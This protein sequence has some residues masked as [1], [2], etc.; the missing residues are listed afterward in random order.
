MAKEENKKPDIWLIVLRFLV[1]L[2]LN[3]GASVCG[4]LAKD[5]IGDVHLW[6]M[7][8]SLLALFMVAGSVL[9]DWLIRRS[10]GKKNVE[11]GMAFVDGQRL[12]VD[13]DP[14]AAY[15]RLRLVSVAAV[16]W[17]VV[18]FLLG[19]ALAFLEG[20]A[21]NAGSFGQIASLYLLYGFAARVIV[22]REK[23]DYSQARS[24]ED[25]PQLYALAKETANEL[26][27]AG[28]IH[29]YT[30]FDMGGYG[31]CNASIS[32][33]NGH[34]CL[35]ISAL[36]L[37]VLNRQEM[38]QIL[39][40]EFGHIEGV[41]HNRDKGFYKLLDFLRGEGDDSI[42]VLTGLGL[43]LPVALLSLEGLFYMIYSS[44][45]KEAEADSAASS[46]GDR[47]AQASALAKTNAYR[48]YY[49]NLEPYVNHYRSEEVPKSYA[50]DWLDAYRT[51]LLE[52]AAR[53][54]ELLEKELPARQNSHPTFRQRWDA[55]GNCPYSLEPSELDSPYGQECR[56]AVEIADRGLAEGEE[57]YKKAREE[58]HC[59]SMEI[60]GAYEQAPE[61][62]TPETMRPVIEAYYELG[63]PEKSE[64]VCER[65]IGE[66]DSPFATA[67]ACF[68]KGSL[69]LRRFDPAGIDL[70]YQAVN[71]NNNYVDSGLEQIAQFCC[72]M[73]LE[74]RLAEYR[75]RATALYQRAED[76]SGGDIDSH[77]KLSPEKLPEGWQERIVQYALDAAKGSLSH[78]YLVREALSDDFARSAFILRFREG[79][80]GKA[81]D[82][83]Y[84]KVFALLDD[85]PEYW[86]F[87]LYVFE[88]SMEKPLLRVE[89][90]CIYSEKK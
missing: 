70:I 75:E 74:D 80:E 12:R 90:S 84:D 36:L 62:Y 48:L 79:T 63:M 82:E 35:Y 46:A 21:G 7:V 43:R 44:R 14:A 55:L 4:I 78:V 86:E 34:I 23:A 6:R 29:I 38:K 57:D 73:G 66:N 26:D 42:S 25:F 81:V 3:C 59:R 18:L 10:I 24:E 58:S 11:Q 77:A 33:N 83:T 65:I 85:W 56:K 50:S 28:Q 61:G 22:R 15:R 9:V 40:H 67:F 60:V 2:V 69:M 64:A 31:G 13:A 37:G 49:Y 1:S 88:K 89:G 41:H 20:A 17:C 8:V 87:S 76:Q 71:N 5:L 30:Y 45:Y 16:C 68:R 32:A 72:M 53:W 47:S 27:V 19:L 51:S 52:D 54:R 39:L